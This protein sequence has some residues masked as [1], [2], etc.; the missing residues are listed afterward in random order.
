M[1]ESRMNEWFVPRFGP[2]RFRAFVGLLF[3]PYTG[4]CIAFTLVG[5]MLAPD[6][7]WDRAGAIALVYALALG[8]GAHAADAIGSKKAKPWGAYFTRRQM[9]ALLI[10]SLAG[11]YAIGIY[12]IVLYVPALA[13]V[14]VLEGFLLFAYNFEIWGGRFHTNFWFAASWGALPVVAGY[15]IQTGNIVA[16]APLAAAAGAGLASTA[17]IRMSR[18]YKQL[19]REGGSPALAKRLEGRL[20]LLS[21]STIAFSLVLVAAR[22]VA[23]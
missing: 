22:A 12:Y 17:E 10:L 15:V 20:K 6:I 13:I 2:P 7:H 23:G 3:L 16:L 8:V 19:K 21:L 18:P 9:A 4:M 5:A 14:A 1:T 11:A